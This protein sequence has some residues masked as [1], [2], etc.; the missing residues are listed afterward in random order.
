M[1]IYVENIP[2]KFH[3]DPIWNNGALGFLDRVSEERLPQQQDEYR[4]SVPELI[5]PLAFVTT[6]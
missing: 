4:S 5:N 1:H 6:L 2:A 3:P